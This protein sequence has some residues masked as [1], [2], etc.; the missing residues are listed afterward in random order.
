MK[1]LKIFAILTIG[2]FLLSTTS[3]I[4]VPR[5]HD[6]G[7]HKGWYKK[8][9]ASPK[10]TKQYKAKDY[11]KYEKKSKKKGNGYAEISATYQLKENSFK[12]GDQRP[13]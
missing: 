1:T 13:Y 2:I 8:S 6:N 9:K 5:Q 7:K 3:C 12:N 11:K 4:V 10:S